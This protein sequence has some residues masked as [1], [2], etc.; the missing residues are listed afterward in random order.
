MHLYLY[1]LRK[2]MNIMT[3]NRSQC[4]YRRHINRLY[5]NLFALCDIDNIPLQEYFLEFQTSQPSHKM[6]YLKISFSKKSE[7]LHILSTAK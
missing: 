4:T 6:E 2:C 3:Q 1:I 5:W 7:D